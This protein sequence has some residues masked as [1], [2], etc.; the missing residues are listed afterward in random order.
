LGDVEAIIHSAGCAYVFLASKIFIKIIRQSIIVVRKFN[1]RS[2]SNLS[3]KDYFLS[4]PKVRPRSR[5]GRFMPIW[6]LCYLGLGFFV[7]NEDIN[8]ISLSLNKV[9]LGDGNF[10]LQSGF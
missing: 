2:L 4:T 9:L 10:N 8:L 3:N 7:F 5:N 1:M 6:E